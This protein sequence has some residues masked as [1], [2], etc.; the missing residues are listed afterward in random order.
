VAITTGKH[1]GTTL[2][3]L[4]IDA[5]DS[6]WNVS[7]D[8]HMYRIYGRLGKQMKPVARKGKAS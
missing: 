3:L 1:L 6:H 2:A 7:N 5:R 4:G 8:G